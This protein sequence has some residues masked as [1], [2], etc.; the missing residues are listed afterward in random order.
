M[1]LAVLFVKSPKLATI[2]MPTS[3]KDNKIRYVFCNGK[4]YS[5]KNEGAIPTCNTN[6]SYVCN[7]E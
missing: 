4:L 3:R 7:I 1:V 2:Q 6:E 5:N